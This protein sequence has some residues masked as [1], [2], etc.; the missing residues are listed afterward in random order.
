[1]TEKEKK[2]LELAAIEAKQAELNIL[3]P[4][5]TASMSEKLNEQWERLEANKK[6]IIE[7]I[8]TL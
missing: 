3:I 4:M 1:M 7:K 2:H 5:A 6:E 8:K